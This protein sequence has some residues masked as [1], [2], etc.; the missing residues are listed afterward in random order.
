MLAIH[1]Q[2]R[3]RKNENSPSLHALPPP[4]LR[5]GVIGSRSSIMVRPELELEMLLNDPPPETLK[6]PPPSLES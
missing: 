1:S 4:T 5:V 2:C 6:N 3:P